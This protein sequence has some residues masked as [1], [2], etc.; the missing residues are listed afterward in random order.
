LE[1]P[2]ECDIEPPGSLS[3][4]VSIQREL[5]A[6]FSE[7]HPARYLNVLVHNDFLRNYFLREFKYQDIV[8]DTVLFADEQLNFN[9]F[10]YHVSCTYGKIS[11]RIDLLFYLYFPPSS[12][13]IYVGMFPSCRPFV[14]ITFSTPTRPVKML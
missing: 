11:V 10:K 14:V 13:L 8:L 12:H 5:V 2:C 6:I 3:H 9:T 4:G 1:S 7:Y